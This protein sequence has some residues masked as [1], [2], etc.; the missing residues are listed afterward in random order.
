MKRDLTQ[1]N[2]LLTFPLKKMQP[3]YLIILRLV[4]EVP[5]SSYNVNQS[6]EYQKRNCSNA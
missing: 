6:K 1:H 5:K 2:L 4:K 3:I